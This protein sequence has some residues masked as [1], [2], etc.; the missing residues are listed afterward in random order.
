[1]FSDLKSNLRGA[2]TFGLQ[3]FHIAV[4][5]DGLDGTL[6]KAEQENLMEI[7]QHTERE[8]AGACS[9]DAWTCRSQIE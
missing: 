7:L 4:L 2:E 6:T 5:V 3:A 9:L 8:I 1:M